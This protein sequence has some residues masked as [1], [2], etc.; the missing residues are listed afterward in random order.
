MKFTK[1]WLVVSLM[2]V[3]ACGGVGELNVIDDP[4]NN[5][6]P[7]GQIVTDAGPTDAGENPAPTRPAAPSALAARA[8][9]TSTVTLTWRDNG[10][11][12][13][14]FV[15]ER[16][17]AIAGG[18]YAQVASVPANTTTSADTGLA[19]RTEYIYR[20]RATTP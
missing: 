11:T 8:N 13:A 20:V 14:A 5:V 16:R 10:A 18:S 19:A 2:V 12:E 17:L 15:V 4:G 6:P 1:S 9:S 3:A 7:P